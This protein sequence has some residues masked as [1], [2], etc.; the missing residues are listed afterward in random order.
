MNE[1]GQHTKVCVK[2]GQELAIA[3]FYIN[4]RTKDGYSSYCKTCNNESSK[5]SHRKVRAEAKGLGGG[6]KGNP[7]LAHFSTRT[8][9]AEVSARG[10]HGKLIYQQEISI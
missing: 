6:Y 2:C 9:L 8:L 7:E 5:L 1:Q 10:L 3:N 4:K